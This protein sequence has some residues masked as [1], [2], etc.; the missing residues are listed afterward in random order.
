MSTLEAESLLHKCDSHIES[1]TNV[2]LQASQ[3]LASAGR[4]DLMIMAPNSSNHSLATTASAATTATAFTFLH[5]TAGH[6][7]TDHIVRR[8][9]DYETDRIADYKHAIQTRAPRVPEQRS[10]D[11]WD[12]P[13]RIPGER[14]RR[15]ARPTAS[16]PEPPPSGYVVFVGQMTTKLRHDRPNE[17]HVQTRA[18][19]E[20]SSLWK[21]TL[22]EKERT[23]YNDLCDEARRLYKDQQLEYRAT[24][25]YTASDAVGKLQGAN[26][27]VRIPWHE[28]N[29]L[30]QELDTYE[31][32][33]FPVRPPELDQEYERR[34][35]ESKRRRKLKLKGLL[36]EDGTEKELSE[37]HEPTANQR[38]LMDEV[39]EQVVASA[40]C[41]QGSVSS[42]SSCSDDQEI[43]GSD[44]QE[45]V[46]VA[47]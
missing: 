32:Y 11:R 5:T 37:E 35:T 25:Q 7:N 15:L 10:N 29:A 44:D 19:Q 43:L 22:T 24:G 31:S 13:R 28:K 45:V 9:G 47:V 33:V 26:V 23:Y 20:I 40:N 39:I 4:A 17:H 12:K 41:S 18:M 2:L 8:T 46:A 27:W 42:A 21:S 16:P 34:L 3:L 36:N 6:N 38:E 14:R 1:A 30:E